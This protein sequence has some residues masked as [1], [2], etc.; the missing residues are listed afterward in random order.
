[1]EILE[2]SLMMLEKY[3]L[4]DH[5][6]GRQ[7]A[8][9]GYEMDNGER[10]GMI[11]TLLV[12]EGH[13]LAMAKD[14]RGFSILKTL[15]SNGSSTMAA[16]ILKK[17][18]KRARGQKKCSLCEG[19]FD[20]SELVNKA[21][22]MLKEYE[23]ETFLVGV[24]LPIE[25]EEREDEFKAEFLVQYSESLRNEFSRVV[26][27]MVLKIVN[28]SVDYMKPEVVVIVNPFTEDVEL[29]VNPL[30]IMGRYRKLE[31]GIP[32]SKWICPECGGKGCSR[33]DWTGKMHA[34]SVEELISSPTLK[35][36]F[37]EDASFHTAGREDVDAR[38][39][40][41]GRP[42]I[43]EIK[44]PKK[45][46]LDLSELEERTNR[47]A[48]GKIKV[49]NLRFVDKGA[50][51][52]LKQT[53]GSE[54]LYKVVVEFDRGVSDEELETLVRSFTNAIIHQQTPSRVLHRRTNLIRE[55]QIYNTKVRR[56]AGSK[57]EMRIQSQG[58]LYIKELITGDGGRTKPS[59]AEALNAK[60]TPLGL[61]VL[62][63]LTKDAEGLK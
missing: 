52:R 49:S 29:H 38:M 9:L 32:H 45:R 46:S 42:F 48:R 18:R 24:R 27:K 56:L 39:L 47:E 16:E 21:V 60:A 23:Y 31:R 17:L 26:G 62:G 30:F 19:R 3:P 4:C 15:A 59:V 57:I 1:M 7:F 51:K 28:K 61:D 25:V 54:K 50:V 11:K 58:G 53:E 14:K 20:S 63:M 12:M 33:C 55:K 44:R 36:T 40:G 8:L 34:E 43:I 37:G 13:R 35:E 22:E 10:G 5:C 41:R 6:L 2:K